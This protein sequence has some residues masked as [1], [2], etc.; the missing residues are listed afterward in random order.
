MILWIYII[1]IY[2]QKYLFYKIEGGDRFFMVKFHWYKGLGL[3]YNSDDQKPIS[4][5]IFAKPNILTT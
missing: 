3:A 2:G 5:S 4:S 1:Y